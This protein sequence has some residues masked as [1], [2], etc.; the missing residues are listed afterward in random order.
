MKITGDYHIHTVY[1]DSKTKIEDAFSVADRIGLTTLATCD[2]SFRSY[3]VGATREKL[4]SQRKEIESLNLKNQRL[5]GIQSIE[6]NILNF[7]GEIDVPCDLFSSL[8]MLSLGFHRFVTKGDGRDRKA[9]ILKNGWTKTN[10]L[11]LTKLNTQ[12]FIKAMERYPVD[13]LCHIGHRTKVEPKPLFECAASLGV[14][15]ELNEKH[16]ETLEPMIEEALRCG[17]KFILGS[18]AHKA[19]KIGVFDR[20]SQVVEK[21]KIPYDKIVGVD[22]ELN[23]RKK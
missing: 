8:D 22:L 3:F 7:E 21:Y 18:D 9:F 19:Q 15:I 12:A 10:D 4:K 14:H 1:S 5:K 17:V 20:V 23:V 16:I 13:V 2:H 11:N 6:A